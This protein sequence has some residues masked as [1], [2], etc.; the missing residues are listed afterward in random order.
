MLDWLRRS[1]S[2][3]DNTRA[4]LDQ[5][6]D[7]VVSIDE[8][9]NVTYFNA[10]A[11]K[12]W[13]FS[14]KEVIG[15]NVKMLVPKIH[16]ARH[17]E[18]VNRNRNGAPDK[19]VG[20]TVDLKTE[21]KDGSEVWINLSLS[22]IINNGAVHYTA[23][24]KD[25]S[26]EREKAQIIDQTLEQCIDGVVTID[27]QNRI[28]FFNKAAENLWGCSRD[29]V[30]GENVKILVPEDIQGRHDSFVNRNRETGEDHIVGSSRDLELH[31]FDG[32][33]LWVNLS[34][35]KIELENRTI[36]TA[37]LKDV[38]EE[39]R[40]RD[41]F[42]TLS[43]VANETDNSVIITDSQG[44]I[45]YVNPG[46]E[47]LTGYT[48]EEAEG[49]KPGSFL[50]GK[51]TSPETRRR[52][53]EKLSRQEAF[54]DE[55]LNYH[56]NG[57]P[58]WISLAINPVFDDNGVL[59][60]YISIQ[61]NIDRTKSRSLEND[62][63]L[64]AINKSNVVLEFSPSGELVYANQRAIDLAKL[65][66][67]EQVLSNFRNL[68]SYLDDSEMAQINKRESL[69][70]EIVIAP[71]GDGAALNLAVSVV[72]LF[73]VENSLVKILLY[74]SDVS[75]RKAV[76]EETHGAMSQVLERISGI[77]ENIDSISNQTNL[78]ALNAA[79]E[80]ARAG[81][82]GRGFSVVAEEVRNLAGN[83]TESVDEISTLIDETRGHV[84]RLSKYMKS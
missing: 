7:A 36:Y 2:R 76:L 26:D 12:L 31:A 82:A 46:F 62:I 27:D 78:L 3:S 40:K 60:K 25:I 9:N 30:M 71:K 73:N 63:R 15:Q 67:E 75:D 18:Y 79:I 38:T 4:I 49:R 61:A 16:R 17:D 52:I 57:E 64:E 20:G 13:G 84:D 72:P 44:Q 41:A 50:Q 8:N 70:R 32:R 43:L 77:I 37:F 80:A 51:H 54:Y 74:G 22:K 5:A 48:F 58:Y 19:L 47:K 33:K 45:E 81:E 65:Q 23:I 35:S 6:I 68:Q 53:S 34:L 42:E 24:I 55:I 69:S 39:R 66:T 21:R 83:T 56:R 59:K 14:S 1:F 29:K 28:V 11:E 10:A